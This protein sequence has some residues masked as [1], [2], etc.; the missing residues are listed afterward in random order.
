M[1]FVTRPD[2]LKI[3]YE[4]HGHSGPALFCGAPLSATPMA[5]GLEE[6]HSM[7]MG[8]YVD[9]LG[10]DYRLLFVDYPYGCGKSSMPQS[11]VTSVSRVCEDYL[12]VADAA[13]FDRFAWYGYSWGATCGQQLALRTNRLTALVAAGFPPLDGPYHLLLKGCRRNVEH[14]MPGSTAA[15]TQQFVSY[16]EGLQDYDDHV[17]VAQIKVPCMTFVG[18]LDNIDAGAGSLPIFEAIAR[19]K[20]KLESMGWQVR[21]LPGEGHGSAM[22]PDKAVPLIRSFLDPILLAGSNRA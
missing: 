9:D 5:P 8:R 13:G 11:A 12:A 14:P 19:N 7:A 1:P 18:D 20:G 4:T 3:Y 10:R 15:I 2:G 16:Y 17:A 21:I 22:A 6:A